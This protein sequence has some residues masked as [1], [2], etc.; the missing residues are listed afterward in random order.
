MGNP[1]RLGP[2]VI[3]P[4]LLVR[5]CRCPTRPGMRPLAI[6]YLNRPAARGSARFLTT[7]PFETMLHRE[8]Y[9]W[10]S[11]SAALASAGGP[12]DGA[13]ATA[14]RRPPWPS[15]LHLL[16]HCFADE[17]LDFSKYLFAPP[18]FSLRV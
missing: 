16:A 4:G 10:R 6:A 18:L 2:V 7:A 17:T 12:V 9:V 1:P 11:T 3:G 15:R 13:R 14:S 8:R 5:T